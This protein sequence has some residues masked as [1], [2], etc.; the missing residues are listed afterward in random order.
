MFADHSPAATIARVRQ[1]TSDRWRLWRMLVLFHVISSVARGFPSAPYKKE[2]TLA[3]LLG[4]NCS[5]QVNGRTVINV[6]SQGSLYARHFRNEKTIP[7][8]NTSAMHHLKPTLVTQMI[9]W[10]LLA[11]DMFLER[12]CLEQGHSAQW[13]VRPTTDTPLAQVTAA[14]MTHLKWDD[15]VI[16]T[17][18]ESD[19]ILPQYSQLDDRLAT[20][21]MFSI[22]NGQE[23][24]NIEEAFDLVAEFRER[25]FIISCE[26]NCI[27][28]VFHQLI[29]SILRHAN[30]SNG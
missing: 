29:V 18:G 14:I 6:V 4:S 19:D 24:A 2:S 11:A 28:E 23:A 13:E 1:P 3:G 15:I 21:S 17:D 20:Y 9:R 8:M 22:H 5:E 27:K 12:T 25:H 26:M 30:I 10:G 16:L 7:T